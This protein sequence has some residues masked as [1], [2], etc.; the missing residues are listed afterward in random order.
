M[1]R[2][3]EELPECQTQTEG[4]VWVCIRI[5]SG[6]HHGLE[7]N[8]SI[9]IVGVTLS[10]V[11][12]AV[13]VQVGIAANEAASTLPVSSSSESSSSSWTGSSLVDCAGA[14]FFMIPVFDVLIPA[15]L[16]RLRISKFLKRPSLWAATWLVCARIVSSVKFFCIALASFVFSTHIYLFP[17][18]LQSVVHITALH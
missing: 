1:F 13:V 15:C 16:R 7:P 17:I 4:P 2:T 5:S 3:F 12:L 10:D 11:T 14:R 18:E 6:S 8:F 9:T